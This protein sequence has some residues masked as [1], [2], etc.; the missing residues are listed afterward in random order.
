MSDG[1]SATSSEME[2]ESIRDSGNTSGIT[3]LRAQKTVK[4][5]LERGVK[6]RPALQTPGSVQG[7][8]QELPLVPELRFLCSPWRSMREQIFFQL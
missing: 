2:P 6:I 5:Q 4:Q 7:E 1:A 3:E 8:G